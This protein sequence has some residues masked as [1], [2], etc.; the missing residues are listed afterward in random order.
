MKDADPF[1]KS[2]LSAITRLQDGRFV[3]GG[4]RGTI[5]ISA[6][7]GH[8]WRRICLDPKHDG[9]DFLRIRQARAGT[10]YALTTGELF[11][12]D[13]GGE[14]WR[15]I[16]RSYSVGDPFPGEDI[17]VAADGES[18][19]VT[20]CDYNTY[21]GEGWSSLSRS[22]DGITWTSVR[23]RE[24]GFFTAVAELADG[25]IILGN[26]A[27]FERFDGQTWH[28]TYSSDIHDIVVDGE[29][30]WMSTYTDV[31]VSTNAGKTWSQLFETKRGAVRRIA[32]DGDRVC[33][34]SDHD[35]FTSTDAG[36]NWSRHQTEHVWRA[37]ALATDAAIVVGNEGA[38]ARMP[39]T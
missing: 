4:S 37:V 20:T 12:S 28:S 11:I 6:D 25:T 36:E 39:L 35:V 24:N 38:V 27:A 29:R 7:E 19:L 2:Q 26:R 15:A 31:R 1:R 17:A 5:A 22:R 3:V 9:V 21:S 13:D 16:P 18:L 8:H 23:Y 30:I 32:V 10:L 14:S 33:A 34:V